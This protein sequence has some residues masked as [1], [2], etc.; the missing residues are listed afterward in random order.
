MKSPLQEHDPEIAEMTRRLLHSLRGDVAPAHSKNATLTALGIG[1]T[2]TASATSSSALVV[3]AKVGTMAIAKAVAGGALAGMVAVGVS[4][5]V[6][7]DDARARVA[8]ITTVASP[9]PFAIPSS[10]RKSLP[11]TDLANPTEHEGAP[12]VG[13]HAAPAPVAAMAVAPQRGPEGVDGRKVAPLKS[14]SMSPPS[15][16]VALPAPE[17]MA[18][19]QPAEIPPADLNVMGPSSSKRSSLRLEVALVDL[20]RGALAVGDPS[21]AMRIL[22]RHAREFQ[23]GNLGP[24]AAVLRIDAL[25]RLNDEPSARVVAEQFDRRFP[26]DSH[27]SRIRSLFANREALQPRRSK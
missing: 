27:R 19:S 26:N 22:E 4:S 2:A 5:Y 3:T 25:L 16:G 1:V 13:T 20:A 24:E 21:E 6:Q 11:M 12:E 17:F 18:S 7:K 15:A 8:A 14:G 9:A 10:P 23:P